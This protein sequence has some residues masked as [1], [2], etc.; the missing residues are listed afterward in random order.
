MS[1]TQ[2]SLLPADFQSARKVVSTAPLYNRVYANSDSIR[3]TITQRTEVVALLRQ[4][5]I[6]KSALV[7]EVGAGLGELH[8][9][10]PGYL[11]IEQSGEGVKRGQQEVGAGSKLQQGDAAMLP[12]SDNS[13]NFL[14]SYNTLE[15]VLQIEAAFAEIVR[16]LKP[17]G[18]A[19]LSPA[20]NCR[21]WTVA[22]LE[23]RPY[24]DLTMSQKLG[25]FLIPVRD[26]LSVR[27][28][29]A[30]LGRLFRELKLVLGFRVS[31]DFQPLQPDF[32]LIEK[33]GHVSDDDAFIS[34]DAHA[35]LA[36]FAGQSFQ[37]ISHPTF[38]KRLV[39]RSGGILVRKPN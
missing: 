37:L 39:V 30:L 16:V 7:V 4:L 15:H 20:W 23:Q 21:S 14:F 36:W 28:L 38:R 19:W 27:L 22:K 1:N 6:S 26:N 12:L 8:D 24:S 29:Q 10:H 34:I 35:A 9:I 2:S 5:G 13:V 17:G 3:G 31:L 32:I 11:G 33:Y 18:H 25:K